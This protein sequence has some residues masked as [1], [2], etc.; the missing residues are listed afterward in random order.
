[1]RGCEG[2]TN[3]L[4]G[5]GRRSIRLRG[6]DYTREGAYFVTVC[7]HERRRL[8]GYVRDDVMRLSDLGRRVEDAWTWLPERYPY[9][10]LDAW[11]IMPDHFHG[12]LKIDDD[13][14][15]APYELDPDGGQ[16]S[17][18][19]PLGR[20]IAVFKTLATR[21]INALRNTPG[22]KVWQRNYYE[23]IIRDESSLNRI[24]HYIA[25][26][27]ARWSRDRHDPGARH[28]NHC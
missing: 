14:A 5:Q 6:Y 22:A 11:V 7:T 21:E 19:K 4:R 9:V 18:R 28:R 8:F 20:L 26:N 23:H 2:K 10:Q 1:M 3:P 16:G 17:A 25:G 12:I 24:R 27:P 13:A 15:R